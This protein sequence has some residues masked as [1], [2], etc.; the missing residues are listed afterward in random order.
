VAVVEEA[1][2]LALVVLVVVVTEAQLVKMDKVV[3]QILVAVE[4]VVGLW[5]TL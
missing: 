2:L 5:L 4:E 1:A 3:Q